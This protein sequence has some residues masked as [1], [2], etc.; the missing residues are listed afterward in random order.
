MIAVL[1]CSYGSQA[2]S[3]H[4][5][6]AMVDDANRE[7]SHPRLNLDSTRACSILTLGVGQLTQNLRL[8]TPKWA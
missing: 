2:S 4:G 5:N 6:A 3:V 8:S 7:L 1:E